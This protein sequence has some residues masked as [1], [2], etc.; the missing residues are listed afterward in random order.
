MDE[1][2]RDRRF[3]GSGVPAGFD[4]RRIVLAPGAERRFDEAEWRDAIV[5][6]ESGRIE[7][8]CR[9]GSRCGFRRGDVLWLVGLPLR[10]L[11]N[12]GR[13]RTVLVAVSRRREFVDTGPSALEAALRDGKP[14]PDQRRRRPYRAGAG[15]TTRG[16]A[17][18]A[19]PAHGPRV[20]SCIPM[21]SLNH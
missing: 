19:S 15:D 8:E 10:A 20:V 5:V 6:V 12:S 13:T 3:L 21:E 7:L 18:G 9:S 14:H 4:V 2:R 1:S 11:R 16:A 17:D